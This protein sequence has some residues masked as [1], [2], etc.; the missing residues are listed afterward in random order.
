MLRNQNDW[1]AD[2]KKNKSSPEVRM[3]VKLHYRL[4]TK[5][6][7][8]NNG[9]KKTQKFKFTISS[10]IK[11]SSLFHY[12]QKIMAKDWNMILFSRTGIL[13]KPSEGVRL[14]TEKKILTNPT[15][16][17]TYVEREATRR[18]LWW[19]SQDTKLLKLICGY[20]A[21]SHIF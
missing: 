11:N 9:E 18:K 17:T 13:T 12:L 5:V 20:S 14:K 4:S 2:K 6:H 10:H 19:S 1:N 7:E 15:N 21:N 16:T 3:R 8:L